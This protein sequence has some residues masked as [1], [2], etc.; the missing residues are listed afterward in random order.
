MLN[1]HMPLLKTS[2]PKMSVLLLTSLFRRDAKGCVFTCSSITRSRSTPP[3]L[4]A[5][6][7]LR[8]WQ[9][10]QLLTPCPTATLGL[11]PNTTIFEKW[12][13]S[14]S[15]PNKDVCRWFFWGNAVFSFPFVKRR[16][17]QTCSYGAKCKLL[18][19]WIQPELKEIMSIESKS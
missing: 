16:P 17:G 4:S 1:N 9:Q 8:S 15:D 11:R 6:V 18:S 3:R 5:Y 2:P 13:R 7:I 12:D 14:V 19:F 10:R